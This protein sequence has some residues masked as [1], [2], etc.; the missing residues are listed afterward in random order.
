MALKIY[1][2]K[3]T[4]IFT[5]QGL[6]TIYCSFVWGLVEIESKITCVLVLS[7][8]I[9]RCT[10]KICRNFNVNWHATFDKGISIKSLQSLDFMRMCWQ[11]PGSPLENHP[12]AHHS[13]LFNVILTCNELVVFK[14][15][16][17]NLRLFSQRV[18]TLETS[19]KK[20]PVICK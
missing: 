3:P 14:N 7:Q 6:Q 2:T 5:C 19:E 1:F 4:L 8:I 13:W 11:W 18:L 15:W 17:L 12:H 20:Q 10:K 16:W 9:R